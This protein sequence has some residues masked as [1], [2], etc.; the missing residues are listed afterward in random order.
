MP[1]AHRQRDQA[2]QRALQDA[3]ART[4]D[5]IERVM[6]KSCGRSAA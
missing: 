1:R 6:K 4:C 5:E 2:R 3:A